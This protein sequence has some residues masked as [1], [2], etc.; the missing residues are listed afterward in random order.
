M[1]PYVATVSLEAV[2]D[3]ERRRL[4]ERIPTFSIGREPAD[5]LI[6]AGRELL[7]TNPEFNRLLEDLRR[8]GV[9]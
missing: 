9:K 5:E 7:R 6:A 4:L 3:I 8:S 1:E 2:K